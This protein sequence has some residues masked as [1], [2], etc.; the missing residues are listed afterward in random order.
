[1]VTGHADAA[2]RP[3]ERLVRPRWWR[4]EGIV[5]HY[6]IDDLDM[7][8][9]IKVRGAVKHLD[10]RGHEQTVIDVDEILSALRLLLR[11][12]GHVG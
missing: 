2:R 6:K 4:S 10:E 11:V 12:T 8:L 3:F 9:L 5:E 7:A 1:M